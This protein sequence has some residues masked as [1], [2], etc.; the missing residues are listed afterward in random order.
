MYINMIIAHN[1]PISN[2]SSQRKMRAY[3]TKSLNMVNLYIIETTDMLDFTDQRDL[4]L[5]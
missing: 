1:M 2:Q 4:C 3:S 5:K